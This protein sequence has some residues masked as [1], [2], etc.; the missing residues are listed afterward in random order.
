MIEGKCLRSLVDLLQFINK[1]VVCAD[2]SLNRNIIRLFEANGLKQLAPNVFHAAGLTEINL[3][4]AEIV[5]LADVEYFGFTE[6]CRNSGRMGF[7]CSCLTQDFIEFAC[8][9][10]AL[11]TVCSAAIA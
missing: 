1:S 9:F 4:A 7:I 6:D 10:S 2:R 5:L 11:S 3:A 8:H